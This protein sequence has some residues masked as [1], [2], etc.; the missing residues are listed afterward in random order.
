MTTTTHW[1]L[2]YYDKRMPVGK[3]GQRFTNKTALVEKINL[4]RWEPERYTNVQITELT[5]TIW[6][7]ERI[8]SEIYTELIVGK[9][10]A[11]D[12]QDG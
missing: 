9:N 5:T 10:D 12:R 8:N 6:D 11:N 4:M 2:S 7:T 3:M 1:K